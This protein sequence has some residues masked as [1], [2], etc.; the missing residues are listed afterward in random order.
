MIP[1][2][3]QIRQQQA[4]ERR[5]RLEESAA[6]ASREDMFARHNVMRGVRIAGS[7]FANTNRHT[8]RDPNRGIITQTEW[9]ELVEQHEDSG[10]RFRTFFFG[11]LIFAVAVLALAKY[12]ME[13]NV[14]P[15]QIESGR[16][17]GEI[18]SE[19]GTGINIEELEKYYETL[20]VKGRLR[21]GEAQ[22]GVEKG[23]EDA[24]KERRRENYRVRKEIRQAY[25]EHQQQR[26]QL[27]HCGR[28]CEA[29]SKQ[30]EL[31]YNRLASQ[32]DRELYGV[33]LDAKDTKSK[34]S[35][36]AAD[37]KQ[38]YEAKKKEVEENEKE[39]ED[40]EMALEELKD[41]YDILVNPEARNYYLLYGMKPPE[42][43]RHMSA[44]SGGW[45][46]EISLGVY[47]N[48]VI[49]AWLD[50]LHDYIGLWGETMVILAALA[51]VLSR[52]PTALRQ[53]QRLL[54]DMDWEASVAEI[55]RSGRK[56]DETTE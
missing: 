25:K 41:A 46:Q 19:K 52:V 17:F 23:E 26:G 56:R 3:A 31:A 7:R 34:R 53:S 14:E 6:R 47:K 36:D 22:A 28:S 49:L 24:D 2:A 8:R 32:V 20:G 45:G 54:D 30:V 50:F 10:F 12:D 1:R 33:L 51:F 4:N 29:K 39:E 27:V 40:R 35:L 42:H 44:R 38:A 55:E 13:F 9:N 18:T 37:L 43:M 11:L 21:P 5:A 48:R 15:P 16:G